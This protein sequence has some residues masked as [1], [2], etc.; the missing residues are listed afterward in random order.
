[1][2][3]K[4]EAIVSNV[5]LQLGFFGESLVD[6][7][8]DRIQVVERPEVEQID[9]VASVHP[10]TAPRRKRGTN[11][12]LHV[13]VP[14]RDVLRR[15]AAEVKK[16]RKERDGRN[17]AAAN[18]P[19]GIFPPKLEFGVAVLDESRAVRDDVCAT[20]KAAA[21]IAAHC[22]A[23]VGA[24]L[25]ASVEHVEAGREGWSRGACWPR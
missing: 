16:R 8:A 14:Q 4:F 25:E 23:S 5:R 13:E 21:Q 10:R 20:P 12:G 18:W 1:V 2:A 17:D 3:L 6:A 24:K 7:P 15:F 22:H 9:V 19:K 11:R